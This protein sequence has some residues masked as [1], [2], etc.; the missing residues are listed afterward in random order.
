MWAVLVFCHE[1]GK[2]RE[3]PYNLAQNAAAQYTFIALIW[4]CTVHPLATR[5]QQQPPKEHQEL[6]A[7]IHKAPRINSNHPEA[8]RNQQ[9]PPTAHHQ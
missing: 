7:S 5:N 1:D 9:Q 3:V 2:A 8:T 4:L 6:T